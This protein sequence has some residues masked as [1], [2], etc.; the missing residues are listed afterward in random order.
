M[1]KEVYEVLD[2][3]EKNGFKAYLVGGYVRDYVRK[4]K[5]S[6]IDIATNAKVLDLIKIFDSYNI[7]PTLYG[8]V[9]LKYNNM[10][11]EITTFRKELSYKDNRK[12]CNIEYVNTYNED[13]LRRDF[14]I[15][16]LY[17]DKNGNIIDLLNGRRDIHKKII[18][19][20]LEPNIKIKE[21]TLRIMRAIRFA[22]SLN[23]KLDEKLK[24]AIINNREALYNLSYERK[25]E[26]LLKI[27]TSNN[28]KYAIR[29][30]NELDLLKYL[31]IDNISVILKTNDIIGIW[32]NIIDIDKT[33][34]PFTKYEKSLIKDIQTASLLDINNN[35]V[36]YKYGPYVLS[37][38]CDVKGLNKRKILKKY[39]SLPIKDKSEINIDPNTITSITDNKNIKIKDIYS[40]IETNILNGN[41][42]NCEK[43]IKKFLN[44][45]F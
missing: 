29:L 35:M 41:L 17:M 19:S 1:E 11:F 34:Y 32:A 45:N 7:K 25:K 24:Q 4:V 3:I 43:D 42:N 39:N 14:T 27:F 8:N 10:D 5:T 15:N 26:E 38:I 18:R 21:D 2:K 13:I 22:V 9:F 31:E 40:S 12:P 30:L 37:I 23:F 36:M 20:V 44:G 16:S 33:K 6:D 28:K